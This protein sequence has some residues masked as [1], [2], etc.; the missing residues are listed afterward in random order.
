MAAAGNPYAPAIG[1]VATGLLGGGPDRTGLVNDAYRQ[2]QAALTPYARGDYLDPSSNPALK[3]YLDTIANDVS[4]RVNGLFAGAGRD[5]SGLNQQ[6]L[7]R[8]IA[9]GQAPVLLDAYNQAQNQRVGAINS[10]YG[11][12]G[13]TAGLLSGLDQARLSNQQ[14]GIGAADSALRAQQW[15]PMQM[16]AIEA[17][18]RGIPLQSLAA[19]YGMV[20]PAA[21]AFGT[22]TG[23]GSSAGSSMGTS[24]SHTAGTD[25]SQTTQ[26][27]PFNPWSLAPLAFMPLTGGASGFANSLAGGA[28]S[29]LG[30]GLFS[31]LSNG[32]M[33]PGSFRP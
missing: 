24:T 32:F 29:S 2:Y 28:L 31:S 23:S 22:Q 11:A 9:Q 33:G 25:T 8:G 1:G 18:R 30:G 13:Q 7:A 15:G 14:A 5:L 12:G 3:P 17:Q 19:Q 10:L 20:L 26:S 27:A 21:Q 4:N 16:L 6:A